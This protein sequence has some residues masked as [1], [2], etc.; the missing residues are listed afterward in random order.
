MKQI[1]AIDSGN[2]NS[3]GYLENDMSN[4]AFDLDNAQAVPAA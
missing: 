1:K 4:D 3:V 2:V